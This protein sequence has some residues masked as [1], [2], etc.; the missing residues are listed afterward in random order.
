MKTIVCAIRTEL[1]NK[2]LLMSH[3]AILILVCY[4]VLQIFGSAYASIS[5]RTESYQYRVRFSTEEPLSLEDIDELSK[6]EGIYFGAMYSEKHHGKS[7]YT[8]EI[9]SVITAPYS[10]L[11][12]DCEIVDYNSPKNNICFSYE[13]TME[14]GK[15]IGDIID[16]NGVDY[17]ISGMYIGPLE[18]MCLI[19]YENFIE[20]FPIEYIQ[21]DLDEKFFD[22]EEKYNSLIAHLNQRYKT[23]V[24][25]EDFNQS[26]AVTIEGSRGVA[27][28]FFLLGIACITFVYL[29]ILKRRTKRFSVYALYGAR[30]SR[31]IMILA[32]GNFAIYTLSFLI[33]FIIAKVL[34]ALVFPLFF[35]YNTFLIN[36]SD[37]LLFYLMMLAVYIVVTVV[38]SIRF[39]GKTS[40]QIY[41]RSE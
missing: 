30:K 1:S 3:V 24:E 14:L 17:T 40:V 2:S 21:L 16:I 23:Q 38:Y 25:Y 11:I 37:V 13:H 12:V 6:L 7:I 15:K 32:V 39:F 26:H 36:A 33:A 10:K 8:N 29:Y 22:T 41:R 31:I 35:S 27:M 9:V 28:F 20:N 34:N 18:N 4:A 19:P 5:N